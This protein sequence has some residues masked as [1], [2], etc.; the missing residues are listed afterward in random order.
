LENSSHFSKLLP[1]LHHI[2]TKKQK[3]PY[4]KFCQINHIKTPYNSGDDHYILESPHGRRVTVRQPYGSGK[5]GLVG[6]IWSQED[7]DHD[8]G[9]CR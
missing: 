1:Q 6:P 8:H 5:N 9:G 4:K 2:I 3:I 7:H